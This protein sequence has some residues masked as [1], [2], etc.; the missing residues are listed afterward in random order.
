MRIALLA[1]L[2]LPLLASAS[3]ITCHNIL[4]GW[5]IRKELQMLKILIAKA[6]DMIMDE[7]LYHNREEIICTRVRTS[8]YISGVLLCAGLDGVPNDRLVTGREV[9]DLLRSLDAV[10]CT[11]CGKVPLGY[12]ED[13]STDGGAL[14]VS[15]VRRPCNLPVCL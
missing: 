5:R 9:K 4:C 3:G 14:V 11:A 13:K 10:G 1:A 8:T 15:S 7:A 12:P 6:D 2:A